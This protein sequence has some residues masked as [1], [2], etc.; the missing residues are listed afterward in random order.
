MLA[1]AIT[2]EGVCTMTE[3]VMATTTSPDGTPIAYHRSGSGPPL[4]LVLVH[5]TT[6]DHSRWQTILALLDSHVTCYAMDRRGRGHSGDAPEYSLER[7]V[8]DVVAVV[9][10]VAE[11][12]GGPVDLLGHSFGGLCAL[13]AAT[14]TPALRRLV[15]YEPPMAV[16]GAT[17]GPAQLQRLTALLAEGRHEDVL[18]AFFRDTVGMPDHELAVYRTLPAWQVRIAAAPTLVRETEAEEAYTFDANRFSTVTAPTLLL[19]GGD[20]PPAFAAG[21]RAIATALP[22]ARVVVLEGQQHIAID[23][24]PERFTAE[25]LSFIAQR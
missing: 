24:A 5:G 15:L 17:V 19:L 4:V 7:E 3:L 21:T 16:H 10:A 20:S 13:E 23:T 2:T 14:G 1:T 12:V 11:E 22:D 18:L 25:V 9:E 8:E 6:A